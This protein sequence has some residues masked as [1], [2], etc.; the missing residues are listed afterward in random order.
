MFN[1]SMF[2]QI[3]SMSQGGQGGS[4]VMGRGYM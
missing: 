2:D 4:T 3:L 1:E